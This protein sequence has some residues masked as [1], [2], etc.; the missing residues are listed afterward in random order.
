MA[1]LD[2]EIHYRIR[3]SQTDSLALRIWL[4]RLVPANLLFVVG[5]GLLALVAGA[6]A[7]TEHGFISARCAG[8]LAVVSSGLTLVH[9]LLRCDPHQAEC[10]RLVAAFNA[11]TARYESVR[12]EPNSEK[13]RELFRD[14]EAARAAVLEGAAAFP[15]MRATRDAESQ[16]LSPAA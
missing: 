3:S 4:R 15:S 9:N 6:S 14:V 7:L 11:L 2:T 16:V 12:S 5:A 1:D 8:I 10:R 13:R